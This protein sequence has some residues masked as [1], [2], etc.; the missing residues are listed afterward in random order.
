MVSDQVK[1]VLAWVEKEGVKLDNRAIRLVQEHYQ[2]LSLKDLVDLLEQVAVLSNRA[3][4]L[5]MRDALLHQFDNLVRVLGEPP[6]GTRELL[7]DATR[8]G[9]QSAAQLVDAQGYAPLYDLAATHEIAYVRDSSARLDSYWG[10]HLTQFRADV[11]DVLTL[12]LDRGQG[13][14]EIARQLEIRT[15]VSQ[16]SAAR[17]IRNETGTAQAYAL[18]QEQRAMGFTHY[19]WSTSRDSRVRPLHQAR[20]WKVYSWDAP[21]SDGHP[22]EPIMCR[23]VAIPLRSVDAREDVS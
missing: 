3:Q 14:Q 23:C 6:P 19:I 1:R 22:G 8:L 12:G 17:I 16:S 5:G 2:R 18:E 20:E 11:Q 9:I 4:R 7:R 15:G 13:P 21:P 10:P